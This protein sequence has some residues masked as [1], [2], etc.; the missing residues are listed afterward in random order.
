MPW[1]SCDAQKRPLEVSCGLTHRKVAISLRFSADAVK[2]KSITN[3]TLTLV[4]FKGEIK[5]TLHV[6]WED[7]RAFC[8]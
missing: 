3:V 7:S 4:S 6:R 2:P 1:T 5:Q 8:S